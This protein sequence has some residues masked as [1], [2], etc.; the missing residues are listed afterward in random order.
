MAV[1]RI[2]L[3]RTTSEAFYLDAPGEPQARDLGQ[4]LVDLGQPEIAE[5]GFS[6]EPFTDEIDAVEEMR[7]E[8]LDECLL[9]NA[10]ANNAALETL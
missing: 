8:W 10:A 2:Q 7:E 6:P 1:F 9:A 4:R 5:E 3:V